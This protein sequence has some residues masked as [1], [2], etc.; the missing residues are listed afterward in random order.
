M[1]RPLFYV[2]QEELD[3]YGSMWPPKLSMLLELIADKVE[4]RGDKGRDLDPG[5]TAEWLREEARLAREAD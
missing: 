5:E 1:P 2:I 3:L 4:K